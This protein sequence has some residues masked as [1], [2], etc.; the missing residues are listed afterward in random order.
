MCRH[1]R[2]EDQARVLGC[3]LQSQ[4]PSNSNHFCNKNGYPS[5]NLVKIKYLSF[6]RQTSA[7]HM[8]DSH[9]P[10]MRSLWL[11]MDLKQRKRLAVQVPRLESRLKFSCCSSELAALPLSY[12]FLSWKQIVPL[13]SLEGVQ[14][15]VPFYDDKA[16]EPGNL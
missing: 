10:G 5:T 6:G 4:L 8:A 2:N 14:G 11:T 7:Y 1:L 16:T 3:H 15:H 9:L 12:S 13:A